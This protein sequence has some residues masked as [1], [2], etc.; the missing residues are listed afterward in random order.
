LS[1]RHGVSTGGAINVAPPATSR[2][3][4]AGLSTTSNATRI[5]GA[6]AR[7]T[8][9]SSIIRFC[10]GLAISSVAR[11]AS[12]MATRASPSPSNAACSVSP[13]MSR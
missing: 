10:A 5:F 11:P 7:P 6:T 13:R 8:S 9:T 4:V 1:E 2:S 3:V 12:R